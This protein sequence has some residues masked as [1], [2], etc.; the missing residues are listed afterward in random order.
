MPTHDHFL[1]E[2]APAPGGAAGLLVTIGDADLLF[3]PFHAGLRGFLSSPAGTTVAGV[4]AIQ[5]EHGQRAG[6]T[7][8]SRFARHG[9]QPLLGLGNRACAESLHQGV[10]RG[11][12]GR[13]TP[14]RGHSGGAFIA[15]GG[16]RREGQPVLESRTELLMSG[17]APVL[18]G[19][20]AP[21]P[22][23]RIQ[24]VPDAQFNDADRG[25][26]MHGLR[27]GVVEAALAVGEK[28]DRCGRLLVG[29]SVAGAGASTLGLPPT[30]RLP[31][32]A[33]SGLVR[34][35]CSWSSHR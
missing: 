4:P 6:R 21:V 2:Q 27:A 5:F 13:T 15:A 16:R 17:Q 25:A 24:A 23:G 28:P 26:Q 35:L 18:P 29:V 32:P 33:A 34:A 19:R 11:V 10:D 9:A 22:R 7:G 8:G 14:L 31:V 30:P 1:A 12:I 3:V 20:A